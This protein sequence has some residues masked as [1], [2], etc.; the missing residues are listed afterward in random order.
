MPIAALAGVE[1]SPPPPLTFALIED[2]PVR[3]GKNFPPC[4]LGPSDTGGW[5]IG[6]WNGEGW[7]GDDGVPRNPQWWALLP[8]VPGEP[9]QLALLIAAVV[10]NR[11]YDFAARLI[12]TLADQVRALREARRAPD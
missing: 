1:P 7:Y 5:F 9:E 3:P 11:E 6:Y 4:L 10:S 2:A 8:P 12:D